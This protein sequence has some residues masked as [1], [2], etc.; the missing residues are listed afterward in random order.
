MNLSRIKTSIKAISPRRGGKISPAEVEQAP[1]LRVLHFPTQKDG[2]E[3]PAEGEQAPDL[4]VLYFSTQKGDR[5]LSEDGE[6]ALLRVWPMALACFVMAAVGIV[7]VTTY[8]MS[9]GLSSYV[10]KPLVISAILGFLFLMN[11]VRFDYRKSRLFPMAWLFVTVA[12]GWL[13][14]SPLGVYVV[15][16]VRWID[17]YGFYLNVPE[18]CVLAVIPISIILF[19]VRD[20]DI[21]GIIIVMFLVLILLTPMYFMPA[22]PTIALILTTISITLIMAILCR[23]FGRFDVMHIVSIVCVPLIIFLFIFW[24]VSDFGFERIW[25]SFVSFG[26]NDPL[27]SGFQANMAHKWLLSTPAF[28]QGGELI[29]GM[30]VE[31]SLPGALYEM[32]WVYFTVKHGWVAGI[33]V[34]AL[35]VAF[36]ACLCIMT[37]KIKNEL[38]YYMSLAA[39]VMISLKTGIGILICLGFLPI[40]RIN[41]PFLSYEYAGLVV[42]MVLVGVVLSAWRH[43]KVYPP[44][45]AEENFYSWVGIEVVDETD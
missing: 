29:N 12:L 25:D 5:A 8:C 40:V 44:Q 43:N 4:R 21:F 10:L 11:I 35:A 37:S 32:S 23:H 3:S 17:I 38:G 27:G 19:K 28:G 18:L 1:A 45:P 31:E 9:C 39:S 41:I 2:R 24:N 7:S 16:A 36:A 13:C 34:L 14:F 33:S 26:A 20:G 22:L 30:T 42:D 15:G 6:Q